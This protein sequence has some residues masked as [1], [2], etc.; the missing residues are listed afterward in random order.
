MAEKKANGRLGRVRT[1][2]QLVMLVLFPAT[3]YYFS[4]VVSAMGA[5]EIGYPT[6]QFKSAR[7]RLITQS[8]LVVPCAQLVNHR[9]DSIRSISNDPL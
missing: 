1:G 3:F 9:L 2:V 5:A 8:S 4:P 6:I 7:P